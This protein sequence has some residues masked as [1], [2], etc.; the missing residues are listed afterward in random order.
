[1]GRGNF[2]YMTVYALLIIFFTFFYTG[3]VFNPKE[4][5]ENLKKNGGFIAGIRPGNST[6]E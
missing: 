4:T 5:A 1:M 6:A 2:L 3:V